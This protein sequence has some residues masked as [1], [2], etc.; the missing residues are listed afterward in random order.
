MRG[1]KPARL[2][3]AASL[4]VMAAALSFAD[5]AQA[6]RSADRRGSRSALRTCAR[7]ATPLARRRQTTKQ[8][9]SPRA[10]RLRAAVLAWSHA[11]TLTPPPRLYAR[12]KYEI[13]Q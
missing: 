6:P 4:A 8:R 13:G 2:L 1:T 11:F 3:G 5:A 12:G 9:P 7:R 10:K